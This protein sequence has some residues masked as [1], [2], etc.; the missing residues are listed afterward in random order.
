MF[1]PIRQYLQEDFRRETGAQDAP[2]IFDG[3]T[4]L[5]P[6]VIVGGNIGI[7]KPRSN[8]VIH[9]SSIFVDATART[10]QIASASSATKVYVLGI[11][12]IQSSATNQNIVLWDATSGSQPALSAGVL[13]QDT[14]GDE[15]VL[16]HQAVIGSTFTQFLPYPREMKNGIRVETSATVGASSHYFVYWIEE[17]VK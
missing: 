2:T 5:A 15:L 8:Q 10:Y 13:Y 14:S 11:V 17:N 9:R 16:I 1:S 7:P 6:V 3:D 12:G 4:P